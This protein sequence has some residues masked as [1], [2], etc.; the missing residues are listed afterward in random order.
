MSIEISPK[1]VQDL[2]SKTG[3]GMMNCK[4]AL[5]EVNGDFDKAIEILRQ[6]GLASADKKS[7]RKAAEGLI[8]SYIHTGKKLGVLVELN[9]ETDFVARRVEFQDLAKDIAMQ[10]AASPTVDY[11]STADISKEVVEQERSIEAAKEDLAGKPEQIKQKIID[12]RID[13]ILKTKSLLDQAYIKDNSKTIEELIKENIA[14]L[15]ENI[16]VAKFIRFELGK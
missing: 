3:A 8:E 6:K 16:K 15:G 14:K 1:L 11:I 4:K 9:C 12:G 13:K 7:D 10:I 2:R 5:L